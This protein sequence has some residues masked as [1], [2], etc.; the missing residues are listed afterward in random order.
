MVA[1][2]QDP[3]TMRKIQMIDDHIT[4]AFAGLTADARVLIKHEWARR[5][6]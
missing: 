5:T 1:K 2:L 3:R 4:A 6:G